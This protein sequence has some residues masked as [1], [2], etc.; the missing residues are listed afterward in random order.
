MASVGLAM[1]SIKSFYHT[2]THTHPSIH[3]Y[4]QH[5]C[6][7]TAKSQVNVNNAPGVWKVQ[8]MENHQFNTGNKIIDSEIDQNGMVHSCPD[9]DDDNNSNHSDVLCCMPCH[10]IMAFECLNRFVFSWEFKMGMTVQWCRR[11]KKLL[12]GYSIRI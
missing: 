2:H 8:Q 1:R 9:D 5:L 4:L 7:Q 6:R 10:A 3:I 11:Y 12:I